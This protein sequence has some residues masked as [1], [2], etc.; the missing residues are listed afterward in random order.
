MEILALLAYTSSMSRF[1]TICQH[2]R[3]CYLSADYF[4]YVLKIVVVIG[5]MPSRVSNSRFNI[6]LNTIIRGFSKINFI[7]PV[8]KEWEKSLAYIVCVLPLRLGLE[9]HR[10]SVLLSLKVTGRRPELFG[11]RPE[12]VIGPTIFVVE[13]PNFCCSRLDR[14]SRIES[15]IWQII[16]T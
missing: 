1:W 2:Y 10:R 14:L 15:L 13:H 7:I 4:K 9:K 3:R 12:I 11:F 8:I 5:G 16:L 6:S